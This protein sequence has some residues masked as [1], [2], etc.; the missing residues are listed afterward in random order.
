VSLRMTRADKPVEFEFELKLGL[1]NMWY[2]VCRSMRVQQKPIGLQRLGMDIVV[3]RDSHG[4]I[5]AHEDRC[6]HRGAKLSVGQVAGDGL[7]CAYHG[8]CYDTTGQCTAIPTSKTAQTK[9]APRLRL[10]QLEAQE[11][12]GLVWLFFSADPNAA[13]PPLV[14]PQELED[15]SYSGFICEAEWGANWILILENLADPMHGPFL[16][17]KSLTLSRGTLE[18]DMRTTRTDT[19]FVVEREGQRG[20]NFDWSEFYARDALWVRL[21]IPLPFGPKGILRILCF[22][23]PIDENKTLVYFL[24]YRRLT[25]L[26]RAYWRFLYRVFWENQHWKVIEQDRVILESQRGAES[27][28]VEHLANSD[29]GVTEL[30]KFLREKIACR[31]QQ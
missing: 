24:R 26:K 1:R 9:L 10:Q 5:Y 28:A 7:R 20:V 22:A 12:A 30:R 17:G 3:W 6:L 4:R 23:T 21:D 11:R 15:L 19:G 25:G 31:P 29:R 18:D 14:I 8:W 16:H 27:R 13:V 2:P